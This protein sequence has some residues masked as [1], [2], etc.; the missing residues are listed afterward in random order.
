MNLILI[1]IYLSRSVV[2][3]Q[4]VH[5]PKLPAEQQKKKQIDVQVA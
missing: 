1:R 3:C 4:Q 2:S 5:L